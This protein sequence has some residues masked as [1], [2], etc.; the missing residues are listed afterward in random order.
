MASTVKAKKTRLENGAR[1]LSERVTYVDSVS[2]GVW[3]GAGSRWE[4]SSTYGISHF[5]EHMMFKGTEK[6]SARQI[7]DEMDSLGGHLNAFT[8]KEYTC[9]YAKV[10]KEHL[11]TAINVL[12]DMALHSVLDPEEIER[13]KNVVLEEIKRHQDTPDDLVHDIF[14]Q[15]LWQRHPLGNAVIGTRKT[16]ASLS[17]ENLV[18]YIES[19]YT[20]D[21]I[22]VSA[23]GNVDHDELVGLVSSSLSELSG[24]RSENKVHPVHPVKQT[25][26]TRK[27]TEQ[28]HFCMGAPGYP[29]SNNDK[30]VL[31]IVDSV[32]GGGMSSRLFQEIREKRGLVYAIGSYSASYSEAG[33]FAVYGGTSME[34]LDEVLDLVQKE[35]VNISKNSVTDAELKR[36]KNQIRGALVLGQESM[37]NR[38]SRM[39]K[40]ELYFGRIIPLEVIVG[41]IMKVSKKDVSRVV[42]ELFSDSQFALCAVGPFK[43]SKTKGRQ[44]RS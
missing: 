32:L 29:Q 8:D 3:V 5:I 20:P 10:L 9:F 39:A 26:F 7:A 22:V 14:A 44:I 16:V 25:T 15:K 21:N 38:M 42:G 11:P 24:R 30:Y 13:E 28:A 43:S 17:R 23:A 34:N 27:S 1:A 4:D 37:S 2:V 35:F 36:S 41:A 19:E 6:R 33:L 31:A 18:S 40:S 12:S